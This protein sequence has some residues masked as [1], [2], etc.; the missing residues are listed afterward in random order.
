MFDL[1]NVKSD[2]YRNNRL[3]NEEDVNIN[4]FKMLNINDSEFY[5]RN[6]N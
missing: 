2:F 4:F 6:A 1:L 3:E 5:I